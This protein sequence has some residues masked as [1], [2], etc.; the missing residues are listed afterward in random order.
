ML[1]YRRIEEVQDNDDCQ[2]PPSF[3]RTGDSDIE[4]RKK[5][6][7]FQQ[8]EST[9]AWDPAARYSNDREKGQA[10][11]INKEPVYSYRDGENTRIV[12]HTNSEPVNKYRQKE[13]QRGDRYTNR[14]PVY[15]YREEE[16]G[17][18]DRDTSLKQPH[19]YREAHE[20]GEPVHSD[21]S[22][23]FLEKGYTM[24]YQISQNKYREQVFGHLP[25]YSYP[26]EKPEPLAGRFQDSTPRNP[27]E[28]PRQPFQ[29]HGQTHHHR[30][31]FE[32]RPQHQQQY[33]YQYEQRTYRSGRP[34]LGNE[35]FEG[36]SVPYP[37]EP[38]RHRQ[39]Y[40]E[41]PP[42]IG[43]SILKEILLHRHR[44]WVTNANGMKR[45]RLICP[46]RNC[47]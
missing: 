20:K 47:L 13:D 26:Q 33:P 35:N 41:P 3:P 8:V 46:D 11:L 28:S 4:R 14:E 6:K 27:F 10:K 42:E 39:N 9:N 31:E 45:F 40:Y 23:P 43:V 30:Q 34:D 2:T 29:Q 37:Q 12:R 7:E 38:I 44:Q 18:E 16:N 24:P 32:Q 21:M 1:G 5:R 17:R 22:N 19:R 15:S 36:Y 25:K